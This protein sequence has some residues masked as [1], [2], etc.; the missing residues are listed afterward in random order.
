MSYPRFHRSGT[1]V[2]YAIVPV[3]LL[4]LLVSIAMAK[5]ADGDTR[6]VT[7]RKGDSISYLCFKIYRKYDARIVAQIRKANPRIA[8]I[9]VIYPGQKVTFPAL[10]PT[11]TESPIPVERKAHQP[12]TIPRDAYLTYLDGEA[13]ILRIQSQK[14]KPIRI[15]A[16]LVQGDK[17]RTGRKAR[18]E[19]ITFDTDIIRLSENTELEINHLEENPVRKVKK[20]GLFLS[21]GRMW[22]KAKS[23]LHAK[24]EYTVRTPNAISGIRG[25]AYGIDVASEDTTR[26]RTYSG[27]VA[28]WQPRA[29]RETPPGWKLSAPEKVSGPRTVSFQQWNEILVK[30][31]EELVITRE[32]AQKKPFDPKL[33]EK[34]DDWVKWNK[35]RDGEFDR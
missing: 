17:V 30:L 13:H 14:W 12:I 15:N 25:T 1:V 27:A 7:I 32:G 5:G 29:D 9:D 35:L 8:D 22:N 19:I 34:N 3:L 33:M 2:G 6:T 23:L 31:N 18:A 10:Y 11:P 16:R 28:V 21:L 26:I 20:K 4:F 24:S